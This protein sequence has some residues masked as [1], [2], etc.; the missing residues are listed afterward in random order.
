MLK[1][2]SIL[3][4]VLLL[5]LAT[6][7]AAGKTPPQS[8][9]GAANQAAAVPNSQALAQKLYTRDCAMCHGENGNGQTDMARDLHL[10][11]PDW[12]DP[13]AL[14]GKPDQKLFDIIRNGKDK[15]P[16]E[17]GDRAT[18]EAVKSL[19]LYIRDF[20]KPQTAK[21]SSPNR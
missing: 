1:P 14:A 7:P 9:S 19:L 15:M 6:A 13:R 11:L 8:S 17:D 4:A 20:S 3:S 18:D 5:A 2:F 12:T 16:L 21:S 10:N